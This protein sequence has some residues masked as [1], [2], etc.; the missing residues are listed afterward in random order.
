[1]KSFSILEANEALVLKTIILRQEISRIELSKETGLSK[2]AITSFCKQLIDKELVVETG[3]GRGAKKGGPKPINLAFNPYC[4]TSLAIEIGNH[5]LIGSLAYLNGEAI[6]SAYE[7]IALDAEN[8]LDLLPPFIDSLL[9]QVP[10]TTYGV[11]GLTLAIHGV[12]SN[13][14]ILFTPYS[15]LDETN[16]QKELTTHYDFPIWVENEANLAALGEYTYH[17]PMTHLVTISCHSGIGTGILLHG[18][19]YQGF[20]NRAGE[21]GHT[22]LYPNGILCPCGNHGCL[23]QYS[24]IKALL[25]QFQSHKQDATL[26]LEDFLDSLE[27]ADPLA[28]QLMQD[29]AK[30]LAT[31]IT[32]ITLLYNPQLLVLNNPIYRR[33]PDYLQLV[34]AHV[35]TR[36]LADLEISL[37]K[38]GVEAATFGGISYSTNQFLGI[39]A[40]RFPK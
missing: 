11:V 33:F 10:Q 18:N 30:H 39:T 13:N 20:Q 40:L 37:D 25:Q 32:N 19:I 38:L 16:L 7:T 1:M 17:F 24:S 14:H 8:A 36:F 28:H 6:Q 12:V 22:I 21:F 34:K 23:E 29:N 26:T 9:E 2:A 5:K 27:Q 31:G 4:G 3:T 35:K 15:N